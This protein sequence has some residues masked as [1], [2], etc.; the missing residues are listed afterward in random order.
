MFLL[1]L[2][3]LFLVQPAPFACGSVQAQLIFAFA[4]WLF[5][6]SACAIRKIVLRTHCGC[7]RFFA[8]EAALP[9]SRFTL[10][11]LCKH[12][13][14]SPSRDGCFSVQLAPFAK[15]YFV[16]TAAVAA[17]LLMRRRSP[18]PASRSRICASTVRLRLRG[19]AELV[20]TKTR[21]QTETGIINT[22]VMNVI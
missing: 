5:F 2:S 14:S 12:S 11:D 22:G 10:A 17:F 13:P 6:C 21:F 1:L 9:S 7:C 20:N 4:G 8:H 3:S 15:S 19:M 16:L 18:H